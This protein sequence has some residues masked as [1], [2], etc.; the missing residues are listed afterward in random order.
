M[1][2]PFKRLIRQ[3]SADSRKRA[4][5]KAK[6]LLQEYALHELRQKQKLTQED[7][8]ELLEVKQSSISKLEHRGSSV[9]I[10][11]LEN[12]VDALGG[13]LELTAKFPNGEMVP[14]QVE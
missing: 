1:A 3:M 12:Y 11:A 6:K 14:L 4:R 13:K 2:K 7:V 5:V 10:R 8:A 9:S